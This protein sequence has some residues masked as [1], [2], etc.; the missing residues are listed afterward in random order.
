MGRIAAV[1]L[2]ITLSTLPTGPDIC[3]NNNEAIVGNRLRSRCTI[4][5]HCRPLYAS[6]VK[7]RRVP[8]A[9]MLEIYDYYYVYMAYTI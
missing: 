2:Q 7:Q 9:N 6:K 4:Y 1:L 8:L 3:R 5:C